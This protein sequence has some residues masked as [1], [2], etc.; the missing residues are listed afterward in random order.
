MS[1]NKNTPTVYWQRFNV[2]TTHR[3]IF[4]S[5]GEYPDFSFILREISTLEILLIHVGLLHFMGSSHSFGG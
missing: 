2:F 4:V 5:T 1:D 3:F